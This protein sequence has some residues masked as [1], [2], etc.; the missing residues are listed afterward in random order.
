MQLEKRRKVEAMTTATSDATIVLKK[1]K[2]SWD[3]ISKDNCCHGC[4]TI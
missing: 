2:Q 4:F 3:V 1:K